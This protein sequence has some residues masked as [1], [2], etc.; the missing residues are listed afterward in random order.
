MI[1]WSLL[2]GPH[3]WGLLG[4][5]CHHDGLGQDVGAIV[6]VCMYHVC[7]LTDC[8]MLVYVS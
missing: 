1:F 2:D 8:S 4:L 6:D 7:E 3:T 5:I